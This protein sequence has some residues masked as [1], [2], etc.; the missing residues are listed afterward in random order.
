MPPSL[1]PAGVPV[2]LAN[3]IQQNALMR[4]AMDALRPEA[5]YRADA[6][7][8]ELPPGTG[9]TLNF[10]RLG[11][12]DVDLKPAETLGAT[13]RGSY[14]VERYTAAPVAYAKS[15]DID[16]MSAYV[17]T[18]GKKPE[19]AVTRL[20]EWAGRTSSRSARG[21]L[22]SGALAGHTV[23]RTTH[24]SGASILDV[25]SLSGFRFQYVNGLPVAVSASNPIKIS[26]RAATDI[27]N[28]SVTG[29]TPKDPNYPDGP[30]TLTLDSTLGAEVIAGS[31]CF[32]QRNAAVPLQAPFIVRAGNRA[33]TQAILSTDLPTYDDILKM[34]QRLVDRGAR[35]HRSTGTY[36]LHV[37]ATFREKITQDAA[38]RTA[39]QGAGLS[40]VFGAGSF[41][42]GAEGI[43]ILENNDSPGLGKGREV[44]WKSHGS[45]VQMEDIGLPLTNSSGVAIRRAIMTGEDV[46]TESFIDHRKVLQAGGAKIIHEFGQMAL[47]DIAGRPFLAGNLDGWVLMIRPPMDERAMVCSVTVVNYFDFVLPSD[48]FSVANANDQTPFKRAVGLEYGSDW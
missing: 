6:G 1:I 35:P 31:Y 13:D 40:P 24:A 30:G 20:S 33:S 25:D 12:L 7:R 17:Q 37:D 18:V 2:S 27:T 47:Y 38:Y 9:S 42:S 45:A 28:R 4:T 26:I 15:I 48:V 22:F 23:I 34:R 8:E 14:E 32:V 19:Q 29:V 39:F 46:L 36:H 44:A 41:F 3:L 10:S 21:K 5:R 43:T 11:F 16:A